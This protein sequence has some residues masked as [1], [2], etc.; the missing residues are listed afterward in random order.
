QR[1][2]GCSQS[3]PAKGQRPWQRTPSARRETARRRCRSR[4][5]SGPSAVWLEGRMVT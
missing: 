5:R 1:P 3:S 2:C 4:R